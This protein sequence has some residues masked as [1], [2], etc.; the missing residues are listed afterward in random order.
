MSEN[1]ELDKKNIIKEFLDNKTQLDLANNVLKIPF[2][3]KN[4]HNLGVQ[5][6]DN[7][8]NKKKNH[9]IF[10]QPEGK[11]IKREGYTKLNQT[12]LVDF[13]KPKSNTYYNKELIDLLNIEKKRNNYIQVSLMNEKVPEKIDTLQYR[14]NKSQI[15]NFLKPHFD[16]GV[17]ILDLMAGSQSVSLALKSQSPIISNDV[18]YYSYV[19]GKAYIENNKIFQLKLISRGL[20]KPNQNYRI[21]Q[22]SFNDLYFTIEQCREIDNLRALIDKIKNFNQNLHYCYLACLLQSLDMIARTAGHFDGAISANSK[23][24]L[25][26]QNK[27]IYS[28]FCKR[29]KNFQTFKSKFI[30]KCYNFSAK[31]LLQSVQKVDIIYIDPPYNQRQYSRYY[32]LLET[33][34]KYN[35]K[36]RLETKGHYPIYEFKSNFCFKEK[37]EDAFRSIINMSLKKAKSKILISYSN[38]GLLKLKKLLKICYEFTQDIEVFKNKIKYTRQKTSNDN[39]SEEE[40]LFSLKL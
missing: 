19:L 20:L 21:F 29:I 40:W 3:L 7:L 26:R 8:S 14:G 31:K 30:N 34:A 33:C 39:K 32:H 36:I 1:L 25:E 15:I 24:S 16:K 23:K 28:E 35:P 38:V 22:D 13:V 17:T 10:N 12:I 4:L 6:K 5:I 18:Q 11:S 27:S 2:Q 37:V 9:I